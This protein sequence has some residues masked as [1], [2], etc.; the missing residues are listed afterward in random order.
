MGRE[1]T[2][3]RRFSGDTRTD[4]TRKGIQGGGIPTGRGG[5]PSTG[6][7]GS[8]AFV[9]GDEPEPP[10]FPRRKLVEAQGIQV[11]KRQMAGISLKFGSNGARRAAPATSGAHIKWARSWEA[12]WVLEF[13]SGCPII[14]SLAEP[15][16]H[17]IQPRTH[18]ELAPKQLLTNAKR[19]IKARGQQSPIPRKVRF[20]RMR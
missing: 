14:G 3:L 11:R 10:K 5:T 9:F 16:V 12:K 20:R 18:A 7:G 6:C 19:G 8:S 15:G 17:P 4:K 13:T 1:K 2:G